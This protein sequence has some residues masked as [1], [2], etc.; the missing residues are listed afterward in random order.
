MKKQISIGTVLGLLITAI[1]VAIIY[2]VFIVFYCEKNITDQVIS[3]GLLFGL[4]L[5]ALLM[6]FYFKKD[7][8]YRARGIMLASFAFFLFIVVKYMMYT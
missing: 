4:G 8:D 3:S 7:K 6:R 5:N 1:F 2:L